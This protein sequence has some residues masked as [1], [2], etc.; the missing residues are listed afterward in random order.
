[1]LLRGCVICVVPMFFLLVVLSRCVCTLVCLHINGSTAVLGSKH[2]CTRPFALHSE[3]YRVCAL[4]I[5]SSLLCNE[6]SQ[7]RYWCRRTCWQA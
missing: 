2:R 7:L 1:M 3:T 6:A 5:H 4:L